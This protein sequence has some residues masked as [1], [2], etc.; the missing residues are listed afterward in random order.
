MLARVLLRR[1]SVSLDEE[2]VMLMLLYH[3]LVE[4]KSGDVFILLNDDKDFKDAKED[5]AAL[6]LAEELPAQIKDE[7][8]SCWNE[9]LV[10]ESL[11]AKFVKAVDHL[12][13]MLHS[14][15]HHEI[16]GRY[17]FTA[18]KLREK[19]LGYMRP[20]PELEKLFEE[21]LSYMVAEKIIPES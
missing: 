21:L 18:K 16:W 6:V 2:R 19:K 7:F 10:L 12:D 14:I 9:Y 17:K 20:F 4:V 5:R 8:L 13:P 1:V 11:E 3:D 15:E